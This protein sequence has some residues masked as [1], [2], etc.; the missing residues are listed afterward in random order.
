MKKV[1]LLVVLFALFAG[2][3]PVKAEVE[4]KI[5]SIN[6][7]VPHFPN[8][9]FFKIQVGYIEELDFDTNTIYLRWGFFWS[10]PREFT[11]TE[12]TMIRFDNSRAAGDIHD[13]A[14]GQLIVIEYSELF[15]ETI[16][17]SILVTTKADTKTVIILDIDTESR[18]LVVNECCGTFGYCPDLYSLY[19]PYHA[20]IST[21]WP[22]EDYHL[23]FY[24]LQ[25]TG[26]TIL[27]M[28]YQINDE[29]YVAP[30]INVI[31]DAC[32]H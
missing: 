9:T 12:K 13:L 22:D 20:L 1:L 27:V 2:V 19:V 18:M 28:W 11:I 4:P 7:D 8:R 24:E 6:F 32:F 3:M 23:N 21:E 10:R 17:R 15:G 31:A 25:E 26:D 16:S 5:N 14:I 30:I 29:Y